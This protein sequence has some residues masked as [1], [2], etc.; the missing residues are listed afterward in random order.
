MSILKQGTQLGSRIVSLDANR[1]RLRL[2]SLASLLAALSAC[3]DH[4]G[5]DELV[6]S[7]HDG[8]DRRE[9]RLIDATAAEFLPE[10]VRVS[11]FKIV[12]AEYSQ[13]RAEFAWADDQG[14]LWVGGVDPLTGDFV[15]ASGESRLVDP[16]ALSRLDVKRTVKSG[17]EW[18][19]GASGPEL[20]YTKFL[21]NLPHDLA[22][23]RLARAIPQVDGSWNITYIDEV[24]PRM[25]PYGSETPGD[26]APRVTYVDEVGNH[27]IRGLDGDAFGETPLTFVPAA[28]FSVRHARGERSVVVALN[29]GGDRQ[30]FRYHVDT[31]QLQQLTFDGGRK[32]RATVP[33]MWRA[34]EFDGAL[35]LSTI[36][37]HR[38]LRIYKSV[39]DDDS[40]GTPWE[41]IRS[42]TLPTN[43]PIGSPE[44][45]VFDG[46]SFLLFQ[47]ITDESKY[48]PSELWV[49][50][51]DSAN[52]VL[53]LLTE[54]TPLRARIDPEVF[55][56]ADGPHLYFNRYDPS[57][58]NGGWPYCDACYE[59]VYRVDTGLRVGGE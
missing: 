14:Q 37:N 29:I 35:L 33:W 22:N 43:G 39:S 38:E 56:S 19:D 54:A 53:R 47:S 6:S 20:V 9:R 3:S 51:I 8:L 7:E 46:R 31:A 40:D 10:E 27:F 36:V 52:P 49:C 24:N 13:V 44:P 57:L 26:P 17:P 4:P 59:G 58:G 32:D 30:V 2:L 41:V 15:P 21:P 18:M 50:N 25:A 1:C 11:S 12:D 42:L 16:L 23:A 34:P 48:Y 45:F 55:V 5:V 28:N